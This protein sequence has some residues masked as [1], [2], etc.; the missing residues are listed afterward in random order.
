MKRRP[1][2]L[3][4]GCALLV[5]GINQARAA[6]DAVFVQG[7]RGDGTTSATAGIDWDFPRTWRPGN[8]VIDGYWDL[9]VAH[10]RTD[11]KSRSL[12]LSQVGITP[13]FRLRVSPE[14]RWFTEAGIGLTWTSARYRSADKR[15]TTNFNFADHVALGRMFGESRRHIVTLRYE[16]FSNGGIRRPNP[17]VNF[18]QLRYTYRFGPSPEN[19]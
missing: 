14:S 11:A 16:H 13:V 10:W 15:F 5:A 1:F 4:A 12:S 3:A 8:V 7:G 6:P 18:G 17:G 9:S 2:S 19:R